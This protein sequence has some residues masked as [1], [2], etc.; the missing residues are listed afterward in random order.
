MAL[1]GRFYLDKEKDIIVDLFMESDGLH[2]VLRT[3]NHN[4][5][6]LIT[7]LA[8]LCNLPLEFDGQGL[9][10][11]RGIIPCYVDGSNRRIYIFRMGNTKIANVFPDGSVEMKASV[12]AISKALMSQTKN[13]RLSIAKTIVKTYIFDDCKFHADLHTHMSGN[14]DPDILI[15]LGIRHQVR[16]PLYYIKK[17]GLKCSKKQ[18]ALLEKRRAEAAKSFIGSQLSGKYLNRKIDDNTFLNFADLILNNLPDAEYNIARI[19]VSLAVPKDGQA[20]FADLEKVY[21]YR[22]VFTKGIPSEDR[23][24]L[25]N[26]EKI[27]DKDIAELLGRMLRDAGSKEY[28]NNTL[29]QD[30]L[31]WIARNYERYGISYAEITDTSLVKKEQAA[32]VL[33]QIHAVMPAVTEETGV[34]LRFLA[35]IRRVP[36]TIVRDRVTPDDYLAENLQV[37]RAVAADPYVAGSDIVGEEINDILELKNVIKEL[38]EIAGGTPGFV[39]RIHAGENDALRDN[40]ANSIT[41]IRESLVPGQQMPTV[42][43]GHGLYTSNLSSPRGKKLIQD[44]LDSNAVL[45]FQLTSNV[46]LNNL[47]DLSHHPLRQYLRSGIRCVQGTD[48]GALYGTNSIDEELALEKM[49]G[50]SHAELCQMRKAEDEIVS[51]G[52]AAFEEKQHLFNSSRGK[53]DISDYLEQQIGKSSKQSSALWN[54]GRKTDAEL[55]LS[56]QIAPFPEGKMPVI[57]AGGSFNSDRHTTQV[58]EEGKQLLEALLESAD[59]EKV[60]FVIGHRLCGYEKYLVENNGNRFQ[61]FAFVPGMLTGAEAGRL[62]AS[63]V[64]VRPAIEQNG[65]GL[66]K[67]IAYEVFKRMPSVLL[68]FDG[69]SPA[70]NLVQEAKNGRYKCRIYLDMHS[71]TLAAKGKTLQGYVQLF[72]NREDIL[73][74]L[75]EYIK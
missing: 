11:I 16:Y 3:P 69:N 37:L 59:P 62:K 44:I 38:V 33:S 42:R 61:I 8:T 32:E 21:L 64:S 5:G 9:K 15:A 56:G 58:R 45:E 65:N 52:L 23:I 51:A 20:V 6:N 7:N 57:L 31:L 17:L 47:S 40:V 48:G 26:A 66:Y 41:C 19:R 54:A 63:N 24:P 55:L 70:V 68:A 67:S 71:R 25:E 30:K 29:F 14:L 74:D 2:Y 43:I 36:L 22:Y 60:F 75:T 34:L 39:I 35:G 1:F 18:L 49:L 72:R 73:P 27:P 50:L 12:P 13:Y 46:R 10:V 53:M 28:R 4:S